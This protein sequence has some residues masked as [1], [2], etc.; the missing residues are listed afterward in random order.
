[1]LIRTRLFFGLLAWMAFGLTGELFAQVKQIIHG[2]DRPWEYEFTVDPTPEPQPSLRF[3]I[4]PD[5]RSRKPGNA[6]TSFYRALHLFN[7]H[8]EKDRKEFEECINFSLMNR[9]TATVPDSKPVESVS[10]ERVK[11]VVDVFADVLQELRICAFCENCDWGEQN[12][13]AFETMNRDYSEF[14]SARQL[15]HRE[16]LCSKEMQSPHPEPRT[17]NPSPLKAGARGPRAQ[18]HTLI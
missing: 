6:A 9:P 12:N 15:D 7:V 1:M 10:I 2:P 17:P 5:S 16:Q 8:P 18:S 14:A 11:A 4:L 3:R 13:D